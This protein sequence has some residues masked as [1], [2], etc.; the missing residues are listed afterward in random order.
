PLA[1]LMSIDLHAVELDGTAPGSLFPT[2]SDERKFLER[3]RGKSDGE[4]GRMARDAVIPE[5][6]RMI[7]A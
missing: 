4:L 5:R 3:V 2:E 1:S 7:L 6:E